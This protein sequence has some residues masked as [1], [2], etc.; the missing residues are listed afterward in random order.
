MNVY[1][2]IT[3]DHGREKHCTA[4]DNSAEYI[5]TSAMAHD[6]YNNYID[7]YGRQP[8]AQW[9]RRNFQFARTK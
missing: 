5:L 8:S 1:Q 3:N 2:E 9:Y 6:A 7:R 4:S